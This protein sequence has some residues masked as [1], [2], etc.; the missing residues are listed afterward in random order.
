MNLDLPLALPS[1][2]DLLVAGIPGTILFFYCFCSAVAVELLS[3]LADQRLPLRTALFVDMFGGEI[4]NL[5]RPSTRWGERG[6]VS[7]RSAE[8]VVEASVCTMS[9][10]D[11]QRVV[12]VPINKTVRLLLWSVDV[13]AQIPVVDV[14]QRGCLLKVKHGYPAP[15]STSNKFCLEQQSQTLLLSAAYE[16]AI[17]FQYPPRHSE[18]TETSTHFPLPPPKRTPNKPSLLLHSY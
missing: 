4:H 10:G 11:H 5:Q 1:L 3:C 15:S 14:S 7:G 9:D 18:V 16:V 17:P 12:S 13:L 6:G 8:L 2:G